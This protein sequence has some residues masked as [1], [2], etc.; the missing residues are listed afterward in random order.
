MTEWK[1]IAGA[2]ENVVV[3]TRID[4]EKGVRNEGRLQRV[5]RLWWTPDMAMYVYFT[6]THYMDVER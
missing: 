5:G 1:A 6:P 2:P 4:D 3:E